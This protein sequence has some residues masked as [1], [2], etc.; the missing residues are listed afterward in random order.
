MAIFNRMARLFKADLH[1]VLDHIEEP[2]LQ[3]K[4]AVRE[5][6]EEL[7]A[8]ESKIQGLEHRLDDLAER[9][10]TVEA[11]IARSDEEITVC[12][13]NDNQ[14]LAR[15]LVRKKL[16]SKEL[17]AGIE[18]SRG[19]ATKRLKSLRDQH[20]E[21]TALHDSMQQKFELVRARQEPAHD[22]RVVGSDVSTVKDS[23]VEVALLQE[24]QR[25]KSRQTPK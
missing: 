10:K 3:L 25:F 6:R 4:Q 20:Q 2:E 23:D 15:G 14:D 18:Q 9:K 1:A 22:L 11:A 8:T 24:M 5:M 7:L 21:F 17:L 16:E 13:E 12:L 19:K